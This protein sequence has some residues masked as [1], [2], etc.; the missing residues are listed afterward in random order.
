MVI[1]FGEFLPPK[2]CRYQAHSRTLAMDVDAITSSWTMIVPRAKSRVLLM[3]SACLGEQKV[4]EFS[5]GQK[6]RFDCCFMLSIFV[7]LNC[8]PSI[9]VKVVPLLSKN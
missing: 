4:S 6:S 1:L 8:I 3:R 5:D 7:S 9:C 2:R